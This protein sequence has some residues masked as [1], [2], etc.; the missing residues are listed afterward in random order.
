MN[1][2]LYLEIDKGFFKS[3]HNSFTIINGRADIF[4]W[5][6]CGLTVSVP[7]DCLPKTVKECSVKVTAHLNTSITLPVKSLLVSGVYNITLL[8]CIE[9]MIQPVEVQMEHC[10]DLKPGQESQL[11][12]VV[13]RGKAAKF[14][15]LDGGTFFADPET[16]INYGRIH[17]NHFSTLA[18][19]SEE[20]QNIRYAGRLYYTDKEYACRTVEFIVTKD[21]KLFDQVIIFLPCYV[22]FFSHLL[23]LRL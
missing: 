9:E 18:I 5:R 6:E 8:P 3:L 10:V 17:L 16:G 19:E 13:A 2:S 12:F 21:I 22:S 1:F 4:R 15:Y 11:S 7:T 14:E 20:P 23:S